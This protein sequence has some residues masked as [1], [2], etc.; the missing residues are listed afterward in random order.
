MKLGRM[1]SNQSFTHTY[2]NPTTS[3][4]MHSL[5]TFGVRMNHMQTRIHKTHHNLDLGE[6]ITF[7]LILYYVLGH[8]TGTQMTFC[9]RT[10][11]WEP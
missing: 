7:P 10:P 2:I 8:K 4:L 5:S 3:W 6:T 9:P 1:T 11:K